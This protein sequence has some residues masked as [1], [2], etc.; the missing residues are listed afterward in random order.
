KT[1][2]DFPWIHVAWPIALTSFLL[3][4]FY[5][6]WAILVL[7]ALAWYFVPTIIGTWRRHPYLWAISLINLFLG[8]SFVGWIGA[9]IWALM[10]TPKSPLD[11][12]LNEGGEWKPTFL[13]DS[14][15][16]PMVQTVSYSNRRM[17]A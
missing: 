8:W 3:L 7:V 4:L 12:M 10:G 17:R 16:A 5:I 15:T 13:S 9:I 6:P 11:K 2:Q 14:T 1:E